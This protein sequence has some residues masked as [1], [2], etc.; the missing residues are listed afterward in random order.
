MPLSRGDPPRIDV[1]CFGLDV[2]IQRILFVSPP[3]DH[4]GTDDFRMPLNLPRHLF[5][6]DDQAPDLGR[7]VGTHFPAV[8]PHVGSPAWAFA[9]H[10]GR[11]VSGRKPDQGIVPVEC[12]NQDFADLAVRHRIPCP[13]R[14]DFDN[15][16]F[17]NDQALRRRALV[18][19]VLEICGPVE[20]KTE[21]SPDRRIPGASLRTGRH[22]RRRPGEFARGPGRV[23][24][25]CPG[26]L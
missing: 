24:R 10:D 8:D 17:I 7:L 6:T 26:S 5:R 18:G 12:R 2:D 15:E 16:P 20:L 19:D 11:Q 25:P 13:R 1:A 14:H 22:R 21:N 23:H 3:D 9:G 4:P